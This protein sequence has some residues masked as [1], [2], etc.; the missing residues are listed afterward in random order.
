MLPHLLMLNLFIIIFG[1]GTRRRGCG[2][3]CLFW[4]VV[5]VGITIFINLIL[6]GEAASKP[7]DRWDARR[8]CRASGS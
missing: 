7:D 5:S 3:G 1:G 6:L 8:G 2:S 4:I